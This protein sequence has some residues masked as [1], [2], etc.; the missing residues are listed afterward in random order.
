MNNGQVAK[1][2]CAN[3]LTGLRHHKK[4]PKKLLFLSTK[5]GDL[6]L[7]PGK[8]ILDETIGICDRARTLVM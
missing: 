7:F 8:T 5:R 1:G 3:F 4:V 2:L 6:R